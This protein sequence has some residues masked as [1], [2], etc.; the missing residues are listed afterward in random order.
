MNFVSTPV[1]TLNNHDILTLL[2]Q[3]IGLSITKQKHCRVVTGLF[4]RYIY[5]PPSKLQEGNVFT[6]VCH[7]IYRGGHVWLKACLVGG[8]H[9]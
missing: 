5:R 3:T 4:L 7:S 9:G 6:P 1:A 8:M 2:S